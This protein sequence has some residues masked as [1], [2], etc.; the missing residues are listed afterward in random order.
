MKRV[1]V[2]GHP[3]TKHTDVLLSHLRNGE[4]C[5]QTMT[6]AGSLCAHYRLV[7]ATS[8]LARSQA[9]VFLLV[10]VA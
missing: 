6:V 2:L 7:T 8:P 10:K 5:V 1:A 9:M 4:H 3:N